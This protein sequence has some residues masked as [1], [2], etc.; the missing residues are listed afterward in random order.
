[1]PQ[2]LSYLDDLNSV[3]REAVEAVDGPVLILAGAGSGKTRVLT[4][5][6]AH[7]IRQKH[8]PSNRILAMTFTNKAAEEMR[9]RIRDMINHA[10]QPWIGTFHSVFSRILRIEAEDIGLDKDFVIY[11]KQDQEQVV[12]DVMSRMGISIQHFS[13]RA[14]LASISRMKNNLVQPDSAPDGNPFEEIVRRIFPEYNAM[15]R[16]C[17]AFDFDDLLIVPLQMF[18][19]H[20][21]IR[22]RYRDRFQ[23]ILVDEYQDTNRAQYSLL[24]QLAREHLNLCVVGDDDQSIYRWR[25]ADIRNI[26]EFEKDFPDTR[27]FR[28]EQNYR[29]TQNVLTAASSVVRHNKGRK[30][31]TLWTDRENGDKIDLVS[32]SDDREEAKYIVERI[33]T[34]VFRNKRPF[35]DF[36]LLY[37]TNA[38]SR[39]LEDGLR[40][41]G[42]NYLIVGG[43][44]FYDRKEIKDVLAYLKLISCPNDEV[45]F[46]RIVNF[47][48]RGIG[49]TTLS[50]MK[51]FAGNEGQSLLDVASHVEAVAGIS[52]RLQNKVS[53]FA[54]LIEKYRALNMKLSFNELVHTLVDEVGLL[55]MYKQDPTTDSQ[56][57]FEN[58]REFLSAVNDYALSE[59][60]ASL[61]GFLEHVTLMTDVDSWD[62]RSNAV[63][64][65]TAHC[66]KGLE[67]PVVFITGMEEGLFPIFQSMEEPEGLEE[68]R[69]LFYVGLTRAR[70]KII[71]TWAEMRNRYNEQRFRLPSRFLDEID[72]SIVH[73]ESLTQRGSHGISAV[74]YRSQRDAFSDDPH[75][76]YA[77]FSQEYPQLQPGTRVQHDIFGKGQIVK[78]EGKGAKEIVT[79]LF[80]SGVQKKL[81]TAYARF[82]LL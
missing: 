24:V 31:K 22:D 50:R 20:S 54:R 75:P 44:R 82:T 81:L 7:M 17:H 30:P 70:E 77:S 55:S 59:S 15:L 21:D 45:S 52:T 10:S 8:I 64:L 23:Y 4:Y 26:L 13:P 76:D 66:A 1:M 11:D 62:D 43:V 19:L 40:R 63:T 34:E 28:L 29:S 57:R 65:M 51:T 74:S 32:V 46:C 37:R 48:P 73:T 39:V 2:S 61:S 12:K 79:V 6:I 53:E 35:S 67:F 56:N 38:Q 16:A 36:A 68:E 33:K 47:P 80:A 42:L 72:A 18:I 41:E 69:R 71:L 60:N 58:I 14:V 78:V 25:G 3:Q 27:I 5:R 9:G 49:E